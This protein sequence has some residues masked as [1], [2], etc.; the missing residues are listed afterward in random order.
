MARGLLVLETPWD[1]D[2]NSTVS[3]GPFLQGLGATLGVKVVR[4]QFNGRA[5]LVHYLR[6]FKRQRREYAWCYIG[7]HGTQGRLDTVLGLVNAR[8][9][10]EAC[11]GS[12]EQGFVIGACSFGNR[13]T[14]QSF[15]DRTKAAFIAG[16]T[17]DVPW[18][19]SML[20]D[21]TF[22]TYLIGRRCRRSRQGKEIELVRSRGGAF[23]Y[24][25][26]RDP[27]RV[28][29]WVYEDLPIARALGFVVH[30][31]VKRGGRWRIES[32]D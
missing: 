20:A 9:I 23:R 31:R 11:I 32:S 30:R 16:Y 1:D 15:L 28:A 13:A 18:E 21:L 25:G 27:V 12:S 7:S 24:Q 8:T 17:N 10:A 14:A 4:Q 3:V 2:L 6:E 19:E 22:L 5:D 26:S 29:E